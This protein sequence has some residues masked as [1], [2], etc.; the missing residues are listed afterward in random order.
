LYQQA[1]NILNSEESMAINI[2]RREVILNALREIG[3]DIQENMSTAWIENR[4]IVV[5]KANEDDMGIEL[6]ATPDA[7]QM[8]IQIVSFQENNAQHSSEYEKSKEEAWCDEFQELKNLI[9]N[10]G[11]NLEIQKAFP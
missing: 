6:G 3:F 7:K 1:M 2:S 10:N 9:K 11:A 5:K 4:R 8:Q